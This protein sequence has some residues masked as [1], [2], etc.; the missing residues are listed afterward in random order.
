MD[1]NAL[2]RPKRLA[3]KQTLRVARCEYHMENFLDMVHLAYL[4]LLFSEGLAG[5][6]SNFDSGR[7]R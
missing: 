1:A 3:G 7:F 5:T 2:A 6:D 4:K